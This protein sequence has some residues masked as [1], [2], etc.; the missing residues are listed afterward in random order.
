MPNNSVFTNMRYAV[1]TVWLATGCIVLWLYPLNE[2]IKLVN[3]TGLHGN[4]AY[5]AVYLGALLDLSMGALT[6]ARPSKGLWSFQFIITLV[7]S[8]CIAIFLPEFL[9]H[10]FGPIL[11]N[12][13]FLTML[14]LLYCNG[15][16]Q[17]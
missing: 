7:Y 11:K 8:L 14:W 4:W 6:L 10:P 9:V 15:D 2:S 13:P 5:M 3:R 12:I 17:K 1:A 16:V